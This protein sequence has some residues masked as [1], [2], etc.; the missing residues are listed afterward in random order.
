M[1][2]P[3]PTFLHMMLQGISKMMYE[4]YCNRS[5]SLQNQAVH[6]R[7]EGTHEDTEHGVV[8]VILQSQLCFEAGQSCVACGSVSHNIEA[9]RLIASAHQ[10][11]RGL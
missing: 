5:V 6:G 11:L 2:H 7:G 3:G 8:V 4:I 1:N 9:G 10:C